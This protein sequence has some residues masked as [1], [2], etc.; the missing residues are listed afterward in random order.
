MRSPLIELINK[1]SSGEQL[2][3]PYVIILDDYHLIEEVK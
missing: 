1:V 2:Y 3:Q